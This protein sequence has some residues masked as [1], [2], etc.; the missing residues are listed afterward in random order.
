[1]NLSN[2]QLSGANLSGS[3]LYAA[4]IS[5]T[6][7]SGANLSHAQIYKANIANTNFTYADLSYANLCGAAYDENNTDDVPG[8][9]TVYFD[10]TGANLSHA[11][12]DHSSLRMQI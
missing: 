7:L 10:F 4:D 8:V 1:M 6:D 9:G 11:D 2:L 12:L 3:S 5:N